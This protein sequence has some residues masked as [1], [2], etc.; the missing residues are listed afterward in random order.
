MF[1][2]RRRETRPHA[3]RSLGLKFKQYAERYPELAE[4]IK[5]IQRRELPA[6]WDKNLPT[7][8]ADPKGLAS[9]DS[10]AKVL[11]VLAQ[12]VPWLIGGAADLAPSTKTHLTFKGAGDFEAYNYAGRNFHFGIRE[13]AMNAIL[14]GMALTKVRGYGSGF[15]IFSDYAARG[16]SPG[17]DHGDSGHRHLHARFDRLG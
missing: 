11:N 7:F 4:Q 16:H 9:R 14:N 13:H 10:S 8:P 2:G 1:S 6:G 17:R 5:Q 15:L 12:N 3:E